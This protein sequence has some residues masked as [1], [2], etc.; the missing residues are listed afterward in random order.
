MRRQ[1]Y[2]KVLGVSRDADTEEI[3]RAYRKVAKECHP[4]VSQGDEAS[5]ERFR[6]ATE[7]YEV[8]SDARK[9]AD[10]DRKLRE[11]DFA[12]TR[13]RR[14]SR[15]LDFFELAEQMMLNLFREM[16]GYPAW[17]SFGGTLEVWL[18]EEEAENGTRVS[19]DVPIE[20]EC[21]ICEGRGYL[22]FS[23]CPRCGGK[24]TVEGSRRVTIEIPPGVREGDRLEIPVPTGNRI[25][26]LPAVVRISR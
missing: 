13:P 2:Y 10:Y 8:L 25:T 9:R 22:L 6:Q 7:A 21:G 16:H 12:R 26:V 20:R 17:E 23:Y 4:D 15:T 3:K 24:G 11:Q 5:T 19:F 1:D 18:T 14:H